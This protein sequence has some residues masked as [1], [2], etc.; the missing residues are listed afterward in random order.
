[1]ICNVCGRQVEESY[2]GSGQAMPCKCIS[3]VLPSLELEEEL[4]A[5]PCEYEDGYGEW[6]YTEVRCTKCSEAI[7]KSKREG[8]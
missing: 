4:H 3:K 8:R 6:P 1:V 2:P 7:R 5:G